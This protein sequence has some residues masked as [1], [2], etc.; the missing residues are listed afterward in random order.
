MNGKSDFLKGPW[1]AGAIVVF[2]AAAALWSAVNLLKEEE[3]KPLY[4]IS[5]VVEDSGS[6]RWTAF[7][8]GVDQA[9]REY[10]MDVTFAATGSF[11]R[12]ED[13]KNLIGQ[14]VLSGTQALILSAFDSEETITLLEGVPSGIPVIL[15][16]T[17]GIRA[18]GPDLAAVAPPGR[19]MGR[20]LGEML[21]GA[22][23][24]E[25]SVAVITRARE[26]YLEMDMLEG[27]SET[28]RSAGGSLLVLSQGEGDPETLVSLARG[29][30]LIAV[31][32][33][34]LLVRTA[35]LM[36]ESGLKSGKL[37]GIGCSPAAVSELDRG[38]V[39]GMVIPNEFTMGYQSVALLYRRMSND[40]P[41]LGDLEVGY[42][43]V[44]SENVHDP[45]VEKLLFPLV[46]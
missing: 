9:A 39:S 45:D 6:D 20:D 17:D 4:R 3:P 27:L 15:A 29:Q 16:E 24:E 38:T 28:I 46:Q 12:A 36:E 1:V 43:C 7:R 41:A 35:A 19:D 23:I 40:L 34:A 37:Y 10:G 13:Q 30:D 26:R 2:L 44:K 32:D 33:D 25:P 8:L 42:A 31:L 18:E 14:E 5:V 11:D 22:G 21:L